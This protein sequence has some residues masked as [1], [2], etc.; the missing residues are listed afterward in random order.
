MKIKFISEDDLPL[1]KTPELHNMIILIRSVSDKGSKH[2]PQVFLDE[3][4][5]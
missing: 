4:F 2:Y 3:C 1:N 5:V